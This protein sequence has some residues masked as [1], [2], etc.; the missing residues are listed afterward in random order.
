MSS[1]AKYGLRQLARLARG[2]RLLAHGVEAEARRQHQPLLRSADRDVHAP[3]VMAVVD[4]GQRGDGIH[5]Q[6]RGMLRRI[7]RLAHLV[8]ARGRARRGLVVH[9]AHGLDGRGP[10]RRAAAPRWPPASAPLRQSEPMNSGSRPSF[11]AMV[12]HSVAKCPV[13]YISTLSPG[14]SVLSSA[15]SHAPVPDAGIDDDGLRGLEDG[16]DAGE[17]AQAQLL[18]L[19]PPVIDHRHVHGPQD[20][21]RHRR[22]PRD[23]QEMAARRGAARWTSGVLHRH[24]VRQ[25]KAGLGRAANGYV[26]R[27]PPKPA[28]GLAVRR[29]HHRPH[30]ILMRPTQR[31]GHAGV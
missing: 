23:L 16:L 24:D 5:H 27:V 25:L 15:A 1:Q 26:P 31:Y 22:R 17:H 4:R 14:E 30:A 20:A 19:G 12:F 28:C 9:H 8:D 13:S 7:D 29:R 3:L 21:V 11:T 10:C 18:E 6:Q 2:Q